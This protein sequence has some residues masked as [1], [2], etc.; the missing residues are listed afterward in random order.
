MHDEVTITF[1]FKHNQCETPFERL[2]KKTKK[3]KTKQQQP[4]NKI[5]YRSFEKHS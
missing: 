3:T 2:P 5:T 1:V 4:N